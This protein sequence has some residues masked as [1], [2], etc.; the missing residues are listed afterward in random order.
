VDVVSGADIEY[1]D[2]AVKTRT[3]D[4]HIPFIADEDALYNSVDHSINCIKTG[5]PS[6]SGPDAAIRVI[7]VLEIADSRM[8]I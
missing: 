4:V 5:C 6:N 1:E 3:G 8:N 2:Y 7:K